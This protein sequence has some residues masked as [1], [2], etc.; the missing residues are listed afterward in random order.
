MP[1][2]AGKVAVVTGASSGIGWALAKRLA[3]EGCKLGL[4]ARR[5]APLAKLASQLRSAGGTVAFATADVSQQTQVELAVAA[6]REQLG[7]IDLA[8]ANAGVGM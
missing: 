5:E 3:T 7:P 6:L 2:L 1:T 8:F 4:V